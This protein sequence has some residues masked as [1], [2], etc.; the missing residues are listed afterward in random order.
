MSSSSSSSSSSSDSEHDE[1]EGEISGIEELEGD[2]YYV[3]KGIIV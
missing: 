3:H 1:S 2:Q